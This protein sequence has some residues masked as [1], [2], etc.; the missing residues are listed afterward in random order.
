[1]AQGPP[2][3]PQHQMPSPA[4]TNTEN[5][6]PHL[7]KKTAPEYIPPHL[8][9]KAGAQYVAPHLRKGPKKSTGEP[10]KPANG[11]SATNTTTKAPP[12]PH[13]PTNG[14]NQKSEETLSPPAEEPVIWGGW[15]ASS[16]QPNWGNSVVC[17]SRPNRNARP[18]A[19][20]S[21]PYSPPK[22]N[23]PKQQQNGQW[24]GR[25]PPRGPAQQHKK[26]VWPKN[27]DMKPQ[28]IDDDQSEGG[29]PC[30]KSGTGTEYDVKQLMDWNGDWLPA[31]VEWASRKPFMQSDLTKTVDKWAD[32]VHKAWN[33]DTGNGI[34][35]HNY[36]FIPIN[37]PP[38]AEPGCKVGEQAWIKGGDF[39]HQLWI[40]TRIDGESPQQFWRTYPAQ[41]PPP[42]QEGDLLDSRLWWEQITIKDHC[43]LPLL[44]HPDAPLDPND[45]EYE[46]K[47]WRT[48]AQQAL[49]RRHAAE[50]KRYEKQMAVRRG[51][52]IQ[53]QAAPEL[54]IPDD[55]LKP[56]ANFYLRPVLAATDA[57]PITDLYNHYVKN[58]VLTPEF[59]N[60]TE[61]GMYARIQ[62]VVGLGLPWI[63]AVQRGKGRARQPNSAYGGENIVGFACLD[64][65]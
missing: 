3:H 14:L 65:E 35:T 32:E 46:G 40:P 7:R 19:L 58:S 48:T 13:H 33:P 28:P 42:E 62:E 38:Y 24:R 64:G 34:A 59:L 6:P 4:T 17:Q 20:P 63:V 21:P 49:N 15:G 51:A 52:I 2:D 22:Q 57:K 43:Q 23:A 55:S 54:D 30:A 36:G 41:A 16:E 27:R 50:K 60:C 39:V 5:L 37:S 53:A 56:T 29:V 8:R 18:K 26:T 47:G 31:S 1:M 10:A 45:E 11:A 12:K 44:E 9:K 25:N 61:G